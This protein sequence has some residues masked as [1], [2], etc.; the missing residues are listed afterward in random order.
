MGGPRVRGDRRGLEAAAHPRRRRVAERMGAPH[1]PPRVRAAGH[2]PAPRRLRQRPGRG[3][4]AQ[5]RAAAVLPHQLRRARL[6]QGR[7]R[8]APRGPRRDRPAGDPQGRVLDL[9]RRLRSARPRARSACCSADIEYW[10]CSA[11]PQRDQPLRQLALQEADGDAWAALRLLVDPAWHQRRADQLTAAA[12]GDRPPADPGGQ[13]DGRC[14][15]ARAPASRRRPPAAPPAPA[16]AGAAR[17][18]AAAAGPWLAAAPVLLLLGLVV[19][20][21]VLLAGGAAAAVRHAGGRRRASSAGPGSL[22]GVAG[23]GITAA[24]LARGAHRQPVRRTA[25]APGRYLTT[26]YGPPWGG[27]Q[28]AGQATSGGLA[29]AGGAPRWYMIAVDPLLIGHGQLVYAVAQPVRLARPV[30]RRRHRRRDPRPPDRLLRLARPRS[31]SAAG[32]P[33][34]ARISASPIVRGG[35]DITSAAP[36]TAA[37]RRRLQRRRRADR[38]ARAR[39]AR[40]RPA[41]PRLPAARRQLRLVRLVCHQR[42]AQ[43]RRPDPR[44]RL[45]GLP[46]HLGQGHAACCSSASASRRAARTPPVGSALMYG[47]DAGRRDSRHVNLV[48]RVL[49][50]G[51]FMVTGGNQDGGRVTRYGPCRLQR[52]DPA[53]LTGPGCDSRPIYGIAMPTDLRQRDPRRCSQSPCSPRSPPRSP[54]RLGR[55]PSRDG[56]HARH[57]SRIAAARRARRARRRHRGSPRPALDRQDRV[58]RRAAPARSRAR[59]TTGRCSAGCRSTLRGRDDRHRRPRRRRATTTLVID[60]G[61]RTRAFAPAVYRRALATYHD[62]GRAYRLRWTR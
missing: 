10:T 30:P 24:Q 48:D 16:G 3:A 38:A 20:L 6:R 40:P 17:T 60:P 23:T 1:P 50:D 52:A 34:T 44:Q 47:T 32:A 31:P 45:V 37:R 14:R 51:I 11:D 61:P 62:D 39:P 18:V 27:I 57:T 2:H 9:L 53:R 22:G 25:A 49:P 7:A 55:A 46:L 56:R 36:R 42:L 54:S 33:R 58:E 26:A 21:L 8:P 5:Q 19:L 29:I 13:L 15:G 12:N 35:P 41:H 4:A 59:S 28:G 43:R